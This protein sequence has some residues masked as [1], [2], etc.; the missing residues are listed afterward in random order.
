MLNSI[1]LSLS[2][3]CG[4]NCVFCPSDLGK[5]IPTRI[6]SVE[7]VSKII[8]E[9]AELNAA[10]KHDITKLYIHEQGDAFLNPA[11]MEILVLIR[12]VLPDI[13]VVLFTNF[14][15]VTPERSEVILKKKLINTWFTN[16][17]GYKQSYYKVKHIDFDKVIANLKAFIKNRNK[18]YPELSLTVYVITYKSYVNTIKKRYGFSPIIAK[19]NSLFIKD[20]YRKTSDYLLKNVIDPKLDRVMR[21]GIAGYAERDKFDIGKIDYDKYVCPF[22]ESVNQSAFIAPDGTWYACCLDSKNELKLGNVM[23]TSIDHI[24]NSNKRLMLIEDLGNKKFS[25]IGGPCATV[26]ACVF[27]DQ[28]IYY[29]YYD[30]LKLFVKKCLGFTPP[31]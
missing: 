24:Y 26:P 7:T 28:D 2:S 27:T 15:Y 1:N 9:I 19:G 13:E 20:H 18:Y 5:G 8:R 23:E 22:L 3:L 29:P 21:A 31:A 12:S 6:M 17:D 11:I 4:A 16:I 10:K 14:Q 30:R 25:K